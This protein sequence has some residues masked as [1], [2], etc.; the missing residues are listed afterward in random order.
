MYISIEQSVLSGYYSLDDMIVFAR[1]EYVYNTYTYH[2]LLYIYATVA[3]Y[4]TISFEVIYGI[5]WSMNSSVKVYIH[6]TSYTI[7][8]VLYY[9]MHYIVCYI[10]L[11]HICCDI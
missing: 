1:L 6:G 5:Y 9:I 2:L 10:I 8:I 3:L 11:H 7:H 4:V